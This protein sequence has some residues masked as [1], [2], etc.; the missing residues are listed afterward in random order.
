MKSFKDEF[1]S[2]AAHEIRTP[3]TVIKAQAQ[4]AARVYSQGKLDEQTLE[5]SLKLFIQQSDRLEKLCSDLLDIARL[6]LGQFVISPSVFDLGGVVSATIEQMKSKSSGH[7]VFF[8]ANDG[9]V[10]YADRERTGQV[11]QNLL[12]NSIRF[13]PRGGRIEVNAIGSR[14]KFAKVSIKDEGLGIAP[15]NLSKVFHRYYRADTAA[16]GAYGL[17]LGLH[18]SREIVHRMGGKIRAR[19][20][21]LGRGAEFYFTLPLH[22]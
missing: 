3:I 11:V 10:V 8:K 18:L 19:S 16:A 2:L 12:Q 9:L 21:G 6:D 4:L 15:D 7:E 20:E 5:R 22:R 17:G 13:S 1:L 14:G